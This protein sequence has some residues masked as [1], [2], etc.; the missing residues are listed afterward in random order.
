VKEQQAKL[1]MLPGIPPL[2]RCLEPEEGEFGSALGNPRFP[3]YPQ[4]DYG[5]SDPGNGDRDE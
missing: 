1:L 4:Q 5:R 2:S 3:R